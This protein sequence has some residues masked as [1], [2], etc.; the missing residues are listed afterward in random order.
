LS[1]DRLALLRLDPVLFLSSRVR[2]EE[3]AV[4][5]FEAL[6]PIGA[7]AQELSLETLVAVGADDLVG[8]VGFVRLTHLQAG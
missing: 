2:D 5:T 4:R 1:R 7:A 6:V 8:G 3:A